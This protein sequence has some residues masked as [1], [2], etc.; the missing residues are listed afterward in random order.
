MQAK[1]T[2]IKRYDQRIEQYRINRLFKQDQK[3]VYQQLNGKIESS[4]KP[5]TEESRRFWSNIWGAEKSQ[6]QKWLKELRAERNEKEQGNIQIT[7]EMITKQTRKIPNW[8]CPGL[9]GVQ[10]Y[11]LKNLPA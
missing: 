1:V 6:K 8:K 10:S 3:R 11:W 5:D 4:E 7:T 2:K 9:D